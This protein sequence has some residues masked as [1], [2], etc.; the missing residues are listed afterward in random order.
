VYASFLVLRQRGEM[1]AGPPP[2]QLKPPARAD[3][4]AG[5]YTI[6]FKAL[7]GKT[8]VLNVEASDTI[9]IVKQK[10]QDKEGI[11]SDMQHLIFAGQQLQY[12]GS[13][14]WDYNV[15]KDS[16]LFIVLKFRGC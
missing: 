8:I 10:I 1:Q 11:P 3:P 15:L 13:T 4:P 9:E 16:T 7:T 12:D 5:A 2:S 14:L 6:I